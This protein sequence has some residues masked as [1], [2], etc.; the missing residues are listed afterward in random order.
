MGNT[1]L[2]MNT[3]LPIVDP[4]KICAS[5]TLS[6]SYVTISLVPLHRLTEEFMLCN[7]M[8]GVPIFKDC[9]CDGTLLKSSWLINS[10][11]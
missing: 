4:I 8:I 6:A 5:I 9:A 3:L 11:R 10:T 1:I 2:G 7:N